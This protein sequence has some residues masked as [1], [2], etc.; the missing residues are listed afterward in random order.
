M[1]KFKVTYNE[2]VKYEYEIEAKSREDLEE[3]I[4][5]YMNN[6]FNEQDGHLIDS[7]VENIEEMHSDEE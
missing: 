4:W 7:Y 6:Q 3:N 5:K 1:K 2:I